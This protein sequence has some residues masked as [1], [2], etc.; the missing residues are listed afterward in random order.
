MSTEYDYDSIMKY[1]SADFRPDGTNRND[2]KG[3]KQCACCAW[4]IADMDIAGSFGKMVDLCSWAAI[5]ILQRSKS[6]KE[7]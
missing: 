2:P 5:L 6:A 1:S 3:C 4:A 7:T